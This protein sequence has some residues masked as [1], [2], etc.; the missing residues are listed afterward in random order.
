[1]YINEGSL[2]MEGGNDVKAFHHENH[3]VVGYY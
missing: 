3:F 1:M 2:A